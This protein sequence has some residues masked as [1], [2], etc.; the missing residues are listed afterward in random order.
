MS[1]SVT[2]I[3]QAAPVIPVIV[4]DRVADA[5]PL[6]LALSESGLTSLEVTLRTSV[7][8]DAIREI[9]QS[10]PHAVV[11]AGTVLNV[12]DLDAALRAGADFLVSPGTTLALAGA[13]LAS[14]IPMLPGVATASEAMVLLEMGFTHLK[15]FPAQAAGGVAMLKALAGPLPQLRFCPT[16]GITLQNAPEFLALDNV[17]CVGGSWMAP[18]SLVAAQDWLQ[19][20]RLALEAAKL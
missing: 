12:R 4:I 6:A 2:E 9:K 16:G 17:L 8:L 19:I 18:T 11:G 15:F 5:V 14:G 20:R 3:M 13:A 7:A 1:L 10:L